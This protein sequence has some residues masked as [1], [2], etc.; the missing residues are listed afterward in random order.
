MKKLIIIFYLISISQILSQS[1]IELNGYLQNMQTVWAPKQFDNWIFSNSI[2][3]RINFHYYPSSNITFNLGLRN[4]YD[5]GQLVQMFPD[6]DKLVT[7]DNG[8]VNL[9]KK[10]SSNTS[11]VLYSNID[12]LNLFFSFEN[13]EIQIG[14]QRVN[15]GINY[16]WTPNDIFNS[17][18]FLNFDYLEKS[19]SDAVRFQYHFD[20]ASSLQLIAKADENKN[21]TFAGVIKFNKWNYDFQSIAGFSDED[22]IFGGGWTGDIL[23]AGFSGEATYFNSRENIDDIFVASIGG[24]YT[25]SNSLFLMAEF[26]YNSI[27]SDKKNIQTSNLFDLEYSAKL[28]S[29]AKY[30]FFFSGQYPITPLLNSSLATIIN[31]IDGSFFINPS[32]DFSLNEDV[33]LLISGQVFIG[34]DLTEWGEYGK[35]YY[36]R[37]KWNF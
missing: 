19:G 11:S 5:Y 13:F 31:P 6:Y 23:G 1:Q 18:S 15:L 22:Y 10:I 33:Y 36:L 35:F 9:T 32:L 3:N 30:S 37:L 12:R 2:S 25:F 14:R 27:G 7:A 28:L 24:N 16:V 29:P 4:I 21:M 20:Y 17:F 26:L 34:N 8:L